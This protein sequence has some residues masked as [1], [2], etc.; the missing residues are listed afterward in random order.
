MRRGRKK[1]RKRKEEEEEET[2]E[3]EGNSGFR[4][5]FA[6]SQSEGE[7]ENNFDVVVYPSFTV[8]R[9]CCRFPRKLTV[10]CVGRL[11]FTRE[12][13]QRISH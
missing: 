12:S 1:E 11:A 4:I 6:P 13:Q 8:R 5:E 2:K 7:A 3:G 10:C 9:G